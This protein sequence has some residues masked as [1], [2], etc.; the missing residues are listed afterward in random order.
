M[1]NFFVCYSCY[2]HTKVVY[3]HKACRNFYCKK[4][5]R[6]IEEFDECVCFACNLDVN[7]K[8]DFRKLEI[9]IDAPID[10]KFEIE[11]HFEDKLKVVTQLKLEFGNL[12]EEYKKLKKRIEDLR[13]Q[14]K[15]SPDDLK[16][17]N[18]S[19]EEILNKLNITKDK[20]WGRVL[21][22]V[23]VTNPKDHPSAALPYGTIFLVLLFCY[24]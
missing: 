10:I 21:N 12:S 1:S 15:V 17:I 8:T 5:F 7:P 20:F 6:D 23:K 16:K 13:K 2:E 9:G 19:R 4:C 11:I 14:K 24:F 18:D 22:Y 3:Q